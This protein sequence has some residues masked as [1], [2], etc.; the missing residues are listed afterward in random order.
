MKD[1]KFTLE[2]VLL[3]IDHNRECTDHII[4]SEHC[5]EVTWVEAPM[6]SSLLW[7]KENLAREVESINLWDGMFQIWLTEKT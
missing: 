1:Y 4:V 5:N 2:D 7:T 6:N 3:L